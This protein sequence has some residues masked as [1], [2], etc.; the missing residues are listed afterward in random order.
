MFGG[1]VADSDTDVGGYRSSLLRQAPATVLLAAVLANAIQFAGTDL[2]MHI[3]FGQIV[4]RSHHLLRQDIFSYSSPGAPWFNHE[5]LADLIMALVYRVGG[6]VGLKLMKFL[7]AGA[8]MAM[9]ALAIGETGASFAVQLGTLL[10]AAFATMLQIQFR[11]QLFDYIFL[12][13]LLALLNRH[14][15]GRGA[16][17]WLAVPIMTLWANL[18]GG[19]FAGIAVLAVYTAVVGIQDLAAGRSGR[20]VTQLSALTVLALLATLVNP[21]GMREWYV[22]LAKF[23]EPIIAMNLNAEFQSLAHHL[24]TDGA[25]ASAMTYGGAVLI[26][27]TGIAAF[28]IAPRLDDLPIVAIAAMMTCAEIY[29]V[30]NMA[31]AVIAWTAPLA[32]HLDLALRGANRTARAG[33]VEMRAEVPLPIQLAIAAAAIVLAV[34]SGLFSARLPAYRQYPSGAIAFFNRNHLRGNILTDYEWGGY[35]VWHEVPPSRIFFDSF[36]ER[37]PASV[38]HAYVDFILGGSSRAAAMLK[39]YPHDFVLIPTGSEQDSFMDHRRGWKLLYRDP[40]ASLFARSG[41]PQSSI[42]GTPEVHASAPPSLFP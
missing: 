41:S 24:Y 32:Y 7:C 22:V 29:A 14:V 1:R 3:R 37:F 30:R 28:L 33:S 6:V 9:I 12:A 38:Q 15:R 31:F 27:A 11:P 36:D 35:V 8:M 4:L 26:A 39:E 17:L 40:A 34:S 16:P 21:F 5:W 23:K 19:F 10:A 18:H 25:L 20:R 2:W 42:A 13:L